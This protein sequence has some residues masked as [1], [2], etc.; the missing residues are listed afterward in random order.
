MGIDKHGNY[1]GQ[2]VTGER[3]ISQLPDGLRISSVWADL[4]TNPRQIRSEILSFMKRFDLRIIGTLLNAW[5][6]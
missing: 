6:G 5:L 3:L 4:R 2:P 1:D